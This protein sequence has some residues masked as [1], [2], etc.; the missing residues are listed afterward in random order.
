MSTDEQWPTVELIQ[1]AVDRF[2]SQ[3]PGWTP[4]AAYGVTFVPLD[5][6]ASW[7]FPVVNVGWLHRLPALVLGI[8]TGRRTGTGTYALSPADLRR[9]VDLLSPAEAAA[10]YQHPNLL[11]W[12]AILERIGAGESGRIVAVFVNSL[13]EEASSAEDAVFRAQVA[14]GEC[15]ELH[16]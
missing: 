13:D 9:A 14:R 7:S 10:M 2:T 5:E 12:R 4:T 16:V 6:D 8:V 11:A 1:A 15:S 3:M